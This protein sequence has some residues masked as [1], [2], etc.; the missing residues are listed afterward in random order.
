M[1]SMRDIK[2]RKKS[3]SSTQKI[4]KAMKLVS[5]VKLQK[6]KTKAENTTPYFNYMYNT[7]CSMLDKAGAINHPYLQAGESNKKAIVTISSNRGL[8]G[9]YN[10]N[11][12]KLITGSGI[13]K[14]EILLY[15]IGKKAHDVLDTKGYEV[16]SE[17]DQVMEAPT[18]ADAMEISKEV[19]D[20]FTNGEVGEIY[21]AYTHFKNTVSHEP[22]LLKLL[23]VEINEEDKKTDDEDSKDDKMLMNFEPNPE[24]ALDM[25]V[26]KYITSLIYGALVEAVASENGARMQAM[27]SATNNAEDIISDLTL[28]YNRARQ[29]SI[30]QELTEIIAGAEAIS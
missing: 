14:E 24:E 15:T 20:A 28:K 11:V 13:A 1:A 7:V 3:V 21:L 2:R 22:K 19:L 23:P 17:H 9:G 29:G 6:A 4:T 18:Y 30:T 12:I 26:P 16:A 10:S 25:I 27:D 5:T 8:A